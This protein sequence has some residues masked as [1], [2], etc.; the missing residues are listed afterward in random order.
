MSDNDLILEKMELAERCAIENACNALS[1]YENN[2]QRHL[3]YL[4]ASLCNV[5]VKSM[6]TECNTLSV[7]QARWLFWY[8]YRLMTHETYSKISQL[9]S[10]YYGKHFT[11][12]T[13]ANGITKMS[14]M[15]EQEQVWNKRWMILKKIIRHQQKG[16]FTQHEEPIKI[17]V[18]KGINVELKKE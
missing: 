3:A 5:N 12:A 1:G 17:V 8:S 7:S 15:I 18:P 10:M 13:I 9:T 16:V 6:L 4:V 2:I 14:Q 11:Q